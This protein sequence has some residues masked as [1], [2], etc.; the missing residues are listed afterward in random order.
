MVEQRMARRMV[1]GIAMV[2]L[3]WFGLLAGC[4]NGN[5][6]Q[7]AQN[8]LDDCLG[9]HTIAECNGECDTPCTGQSLC[10]AKCVNAADCPAIKDAFSGMPTSVSKSFT[11]CTTSCATAK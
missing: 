10:S 7:K 5:E 1:A 3:A 6:C 4:D 9:N 2:G 8:H 11:D